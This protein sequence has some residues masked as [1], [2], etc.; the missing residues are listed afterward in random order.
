MHIKPVKAGMAVG[1]TAVVM[2]IIWAVI[3]ALGW[4][5]GF[6]NFVFTAH[7]VRPQFVVGSFDFATTL[8]LLV[9]V[10]LVGYVVGFI[11]ANVWNRVG[12]E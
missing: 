10:G 8:M 5:Q 6:L 3:V 7:M 4:G 2:H 11:F 1:G 12:S 9:L